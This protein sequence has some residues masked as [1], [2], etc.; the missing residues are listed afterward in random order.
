MTS[1]NTIN[2]ILQNEQSLLFISKKSEMGFWDY[3]IFGLLS[4]IF[5][6]KRDYLLITKKRLVYII[7]DEII[8]NIEYND[9]S[10][11]QFNHFSDRVSFIDTLNNNRYLN[12]KGLRLSYEEIQKIKSALSKNEK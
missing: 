11:I 7:N 12:L 6:K 10:K 9:F 2:A 4:L 3:Q 5:N 8:K 1:L